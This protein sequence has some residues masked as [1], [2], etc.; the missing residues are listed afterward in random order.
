MPFVEDRNEHP[1]IV[2]AQQRIERHIGVPV[3][4]VWLVGSSWECDVRHPQLRP[5]HAAVARTEAGAYWVVDMGRTAMGTARTYVQR[6]P[7][8]PDLVAGLHE[9]PPLYPATTPLEMIPGYTL[10]LGT[11]A[12]PWAPR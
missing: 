12:M 9:L 4:T 3:D 5:V 11:I 6:V 1:L 7:Y 8:D 10:M 2:Q